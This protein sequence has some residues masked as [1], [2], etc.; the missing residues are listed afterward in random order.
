MHA[1]TIDH[2]FGSLHYTKPV[3]EIREA[4]RKK[5]EQIRAKVEERQGRLE[6]LRR[7]Y[8]VSDADIIQ[9]LTMARKQARHDLGPVSYTYNKLS[10]SPGGGTRMEE[11][12]IGAGVV[13]NLL[14]E[15]DFI[16][17]ERE[18]AKKLDFII[19]NLKPIIRFSDTGAPY[20]Q[21]EFSLSQDELEF[22]GF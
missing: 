1:Q 15:S 13:N 6:R 20:T 3:A 16:E 8:D 14:T 11:K 21:T 12:T 2:M 10:S 18:Q 9:L 4:C 22:L 7:E 17:A 5:A 19:R